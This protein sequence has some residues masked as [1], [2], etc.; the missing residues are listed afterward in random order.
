MVVVY[1]VM[2]MRRPA[3]SGAFG[4]VTVKTPSRR[5]AVMRSPST[6]LGRWNV[7]LKAP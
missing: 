5:S 6:G 2:W 1:V 3:A 7:R 4:H